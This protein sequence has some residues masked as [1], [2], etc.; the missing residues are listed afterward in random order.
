MSNRQVMSDR[1]RD[2]GSESSEDDDRSDDSLS[3]EDRHSRRDQSETGDETDSEDQIPKV[4]FSKLSLCASHKPG[5][6]TREC[7]SCCEA[8]NIV[9]KRRIPELLAREPGSDLLSRYANR[10]DQVKPTLSLSDSVLALGKQTFTKGQFRDKKIFAEMTKKYLTLPQSQNKDLTLDIMTEDLFKKYR[11][12]KKFNH[13]FKFQGDMQAS[14]KNLR[15]SQRVVLSMIDDTNNELTTLREFGVSAGLQFSVDPPLRTGTGV[16]RDTRQLLNHLHI[17]SDSEVFPRPSLDSFFTLMA[18]E[19]KEVS[20]ENKEYLINILK[21]YRFDMGSKFIQLFKKFASF[22]NSMDDKEIFYMD[23]YSHADAG[24][25]ELQRERM[26]S[27]FKSNIRDE[28]LEES[29][30]KRK[31]EDNK[32]DPQGLFGGD[33]YLSFS[34]FNCN[35]ENFYFQ[36]TRSS[37][38]PSAAPPRMTMS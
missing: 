31:E 19:N 29:S 21:E 24:F 32:K 15:L 1:D 37:N 26:A 30:S 20:D 10:C 35:S 34:C 7:K 27:L 36:E 12:T 17:S 22:L 33:F 13:V 5:S 8:L 11:K 14:H 25:R 28:I 23:M 9:D 6:M 4:D 16:P 3:D 38:P 2:S 18:E